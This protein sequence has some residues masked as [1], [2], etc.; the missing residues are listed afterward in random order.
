MSKIK[1]LLVL[2]IIFPIAD[3]VMGT[4]AM[5]WLR[6]M[7]EMSI[8][9][10]DEIEAWQT[11]RLKQ[12]VYQAYN[13]T[14]YYKEVFDELGL[15]P[16]DIVTADD[17]MKLPVLTKEIIRNRFNDIIPDNIK[18]YKY[19]YSSTGGSTGTPFRFIVDE[20]TWGFITANKIFS[21]KTTG[22][23]YG[24]LFISLGSASLF[25]V[26]KKSPIHEIYFRLRNT[27]PLNGMNM[28]DEVCERYVQIIRKYKVKYIYGYAS[29]IYLLALYVKKQQYND[30]KMK[31][32]FATAE[33]LTDEYRQIIES[34]WNVRVV[35][36]YG[37]RDGGVTAYEIERGHY[38][39]GYNTICQTETRTDT[40]ST[41]YCTNIIDLA[42]P[43]LRYEVG[44]E[45]VLATDMNKYNYNGQVIKQ[46]IGR[47]SDVIL[48]D[49]G[50]KLTTS[51]FAFHDFN[52]DAFRIMKLDGKTLKIEIQKRDNFSKEEEKLMID[53]VKKHAG[54]DCEIRLEYVER[55]EPLKNGK[56]SFFIN[57]KE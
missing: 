2:N 54:N 12:L 36:C 41:L 9:T 47:T 10:R 50:R 45:V 13:H 42:F 24:D 52:Y 1:E 7:N 20:N 30:I 21:W 53:T 55:F 27:I 15:K 46:L 19:R 43:M 8:W 31:A 38:N 51:G 26:N 14:V 17:L 25:P 4:N 16:E 29:A 40:F 39:V 44:D 57:D 11:D 28:D 35:D 6:R 33:K 23:H 32:V 48:L 49:N 22:Y 3:L 5:R 18:K 56:R 34:T 37:A